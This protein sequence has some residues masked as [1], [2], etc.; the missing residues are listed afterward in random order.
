MRP[1]G[2]MQE[3]MKRMPNSAPNLMQSPTQGPAQAFGPLAPTGPGP[4]GNL[5]GFLQMALKGLGNVRPG[6]GQKTKVSLGS[7]VHPGI[8][9]VRRQQA[10]KRKLLK[11]AEPRSGV[12]RP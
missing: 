7:G 8:E 4:E 6:T 11:T 10:I 2:L 3:L 12:I 1:Q 5:Q 9:A